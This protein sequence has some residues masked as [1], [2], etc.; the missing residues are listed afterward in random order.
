M[1]GVASGFTQVVRLGP[2]A[3]STTV[4]NGPSYIIIDSLDITVPASGAGVIVTGSTG[5][6]VQNRHVHGANTG[7][8][9]AIVNSNNGR[10]E[11]NEVNTTAATP[12]TPG[13]ATYCGGISIYYTST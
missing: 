8:G 11:N 12:G 9:I 7:A 6:V 5:W 2:T 13:S 4:F 3:V 1:A 10:V